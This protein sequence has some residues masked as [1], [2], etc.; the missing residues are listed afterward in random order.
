MYVC[1]DIETT[2]LDPKKDHIIEV[3][4]VKFDDGKIIDEWSSL[5]KCSIK[6]PE[7]TKRLTGITDEMLTDAPSLDEV[8]DIIKEKIGDLP[9]MGHYIH[10]DVNFLNA[11][12]FNLQNTQI[13]S[14]Q[15]VQVL[16][17]K[18]PSYSL[19]VLAE[20]L[21]IV[22]D[23]AHRA[24]DDVKANIV[25]MW[26]MYSHIKSLSTEEKA[27]IEPI[28]KRSNWSWATHI[29]KWIKEDD[30]GERIEETKSKRSTNSE[31]HAD[32]KTLA[33]DL[34]TPFL[35]EEVSHTYQ[36]LIDYSMALDG[37]VLLAVPEL[38]TFPVH[39]EAVLLKHPNQYVDEERLASYV[40]KEELSL[41]ETLLGLKVTLWLHHTEHGEHSE[42]RMIREEEDAWLNIAC[43][44]SESPKSYYKKA[45]DQASQSKISVIDHQHFLKDRSRKEP[46]LA[47]P[48]NMIIGQTEQLLKGME[49]AWHIRMSEGRFLQ[50]LQHLKEENPEKEEVLTH[51][52]SKVSILF[53]L[54]GMVLQKHSDENLRY[55]LVIE[56]FHHN[57]LEW[58]NVRDSA[59]SIQ[60]AL[61]ALGD[62]IKDSPSK[63][64]LMKNLTY[65]RKI[66]NAKGPMLWLTLTRDNSPILNAFPE[67]RFQI[68]QER[69]WKTDAK[70]HLF[71]HH[72]R[73]K[74]NFDFLTK[75]LGLPENLTTH[76]SDDVIPLP[77]MET[78]TKIS[79]PN[80]PKNVM[81]VVHEL[82]L[83]LPD[84]KGNVL[85]L[86]TSKFSAEQFYYKLPN[87]A[88]E[89][90]R[91]L[92]VQNMGG[93][94]GKI[95]KMAQK[96]DGINLF[97]GNEHFMKFLLN[98]GVDLKFL[99]VHRLPF[100]PPNA[101]IQKVRASAYGNHYLEF[102]LPQAQLNFFGI[103]NR[104]LGNNWE[105]KNILVVDPRV[106]NML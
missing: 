80:E 35:L 100:S 20:K 7:F 42:L 105:D 94:M 64:Q 27:S 93:G 13:D 36:D 96:T 30:G 43:Q 103:L 14:F 24:L 70:L 60:S 89:T 69:V 33:D 44:E 19:E 97:V 88:K 3:A 51:L 50:S 39:P 57:T 83:H 99:V 34:E 6:L 48:E 66:I 31:K 9:I 58:Q 45:Q 90:E 29:L 15:L 92:Y 61:E 82:G 72:G 54:L 49:Y 10:F 78:Q 32:L 5:I 102:G 26:K 101:P 38:S 17:A 104:F 53:G 84:I 55:M 23:D 11:N 71:C 106:G 98:E 77:I 56:P 37:K 8:K 4:V 21:N 65:L 76:H 46:G 47:L 52:S 81:D 63:I 22:Q 73:Y 91:K 18:E 68:F 59:D 67:N 12:D 28:L 16:L 87:L 40:N 86:V 75:E 25:L 41:T 79:K 2:G 95:Y 1:V 62:D 85:L 74:H